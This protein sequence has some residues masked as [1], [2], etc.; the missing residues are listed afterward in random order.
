MCFLG[1]Q[2][3][4]AQLIG[5]YADLL[6]SRMMLS[7]RSKALVFKYDRYSQNRRAFVS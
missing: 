2:M 3:P 4:G 6:T 5:C 7:E 1:D